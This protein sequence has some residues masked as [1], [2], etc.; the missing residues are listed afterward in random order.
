MTAGRRNLVVA[1]IEQDWWSVM[2]VSCDIPLRQFGN[3]D[4]KISALGTFPSIRSRRKP[5]R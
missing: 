4:V 3:K 1:V 2:Q 5:W